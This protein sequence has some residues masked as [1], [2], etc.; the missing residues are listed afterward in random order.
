MAY[1]KIVSVATAQAGS[2]E[3]QDVKN[4]LG[5]D[6]IDWICEPYVKEEQKD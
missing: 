2:W 4:M 1:T 3:D 5:S 6:L